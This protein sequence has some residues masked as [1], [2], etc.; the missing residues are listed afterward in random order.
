[1]TFSIRDASPGDHGELVA[2]WTAVWSLT[3]PQIDFVARRGFIAGR[4]NEFVHLPKRS[5]LAT[6]PDGTIV[7]FSLVDPDAHLLEQIAVAPEARGGNAASALLDDAI[8]LSPGWMELT[9]NKDNPR[10]VAFYR[11]HGFAITGE[12]ISAAS[13]LPL[14]S[15]RRDGQ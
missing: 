3:L 2:L 6:R 13:G 1:M 7:G 14:W 11:K 12:S 9:V 15:M 4:L 8:A 5:R 10:A